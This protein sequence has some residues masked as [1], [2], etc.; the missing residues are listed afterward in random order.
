MARVDD[1]VD[2]DVKVRLTADT[3]IEPKGAVPAKGMGA[4]AVLLTPADDAVVYTARNLVLDVHPDRPGRD[5]A[6]KPLRA[7]GTIAALPDGDTLLGQWML[8]VPDLADLSFAV[9]EK[10]KITPK[11]AAPAVGD[12][13]CVVLRNTDAGWVAESIQLKRERDD[14][15]DHPR[16]VELRGTVTAM[17][18][19]AGFLTLDVKGRGEVMVKVVEGETE[20]EGELA[21]GAE[22]A[23]RAEMRTNDVG[24]EYLLAL[25]IKVLGDDHPGGK[26]AH[27]AVVFRGE[28]S[29]VNATTDVWTIIQGDKMWQVIVN[30]TT[31]KIG[32]GA[33]DNLVGR[34]VKGVAKPQADGSLLAIMLQ[35]KKQ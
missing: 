21:V 6:S 12:A 9:N 26:D 29:A 34:E 18:N 11:D 1:A 31:K 14:E 17:P 3:R 8:T 2:D 13:A 33:A 23:V 25:K 7:C 19:D 20:V 30:D 24:D 32:L 16:R 27:A 4:K 5:P 22:V 28:V 35:F 10:T 15:S